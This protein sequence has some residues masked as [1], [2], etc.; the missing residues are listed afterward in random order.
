MADVKWIKITTN[1]FEDE[2]FDAIETLS[3]RNM[4]QLAWIKL[5]CL[6]GRC[7]DNGF[8]TLANEIPYTDEM[9]ANRFN[10]SVGDVQR[11]LQM[12]QYLGMIEVVDNVYMVSNWLKYQS[13]KGLDEIRENG[14]E[15]TKR[16]RQRQ[17]LLKA[18]DVCQYCG[19][20]ATGVDHIIAVARGG[21]DEE[22][23]KVP[24]CIECNRIKN[25][26][27]L[28]DFLNANRSRIND[29]IVLNNDKL[30][31]FVCL[32]E[33][34]RYV[35]VTS[36]R[37]VTR[38]ISISHNDNNIVKEIIDYLNNKAN[39]KYKYTSDKTR[40]YIHARLGEGFTIEDFKTVIDKK[41]AEWLGTEWEK[42]L[43]PETLFGTKFESYLNQKAVVKKAQQETVDEWLARK[44][45]EQND[46]G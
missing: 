1:I 30:R 19:G 44:E 23:N 22:Y 45:R 11:A 34:G 14:R 43:R 3:D 5:L 2:K 10:M 36:H 37:N 26:K 39:T 41:C 46:S 21:L 16:W 6:A 4:I 40:K 7:N 17:K 38:S 20:E 27:P 8:L 13:V 18:K 24:C 9:I 29:D 33:R 28:V 12:F 15:R 25:D 31:E 35:T 42:Y 32:D